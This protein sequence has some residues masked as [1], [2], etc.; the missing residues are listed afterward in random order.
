MYITAS[1]QNEKNMLR[2]F[3]WKLQSAACHL[4]FK[5]EYGVSFESTHSTYFLFKKENTNLIFAII[6]AFYLWLPA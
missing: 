6:H 1:Q 4:Q 2:G 5:T 3:W